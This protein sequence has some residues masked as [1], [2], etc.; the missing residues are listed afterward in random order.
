MSKVY[1][2][3]VRVGDGLRLPHKAWICPMGSTSVREGEPGMWRENRQER[4]WRPGERMSEGPLFPT[5]S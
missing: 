4:T 2:L 5:R 1:E 3:E